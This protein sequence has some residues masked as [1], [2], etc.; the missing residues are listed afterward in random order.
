MSECNDT[1]EYKNSLNLTGT[2]GFLYSPTIQF[3]QLDKIQSDFIKTI[4]VLPDTNINSFIDNYGQ[5]KFNES[6]LS[7][8]NFLYSANLNVNLNLKVNYPLVQE[9]LDKGVAIT[10]IEFSSFM[11]EAGYNPI[12]IQTQQVSNPKK[13]L[14]LFNTY[15]NGAFSKS[16]MGSFCELAPSIFGAVA[17]FFTSVRNLA[18]TITDIINSIQNFSLA[19]LLDSLKKKILDVV[20]SAINKVKSIIENLSLQGVMD[21]AQ[22]IFQ[23]RVLY[24]FKQIKDQA[25]AFFEKDNVE[26]FTK[27]IEG[28]ISYATGLFK[29]IDIEEIQ[30]LIYRFCSFI[31]Q[32]ENIING[33]RNPIDAFSNRYISTYNLLKVRSDLNT[34]SAVAAG[35]K[36]FNND[37]VYAGA[38]SGIG[39]ETA[40]GNA[41]PPSQAE[42]D[43]VT[44]WNDGNGDGRITFVGGARDRGIESWTRVTPN[45]RVLAMRLQAKFGRQLK[46]TSAYRSTETQRQIIQK[47]VN[48]GKYPSFEAAIAS[49]KYARPGNSLHEKGTALDV[50][51]DGFNS[52]SKAEFIRIAREVGFSGIGGGYDTFV[53]IDTGPKREW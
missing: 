25:L 53:H 37:E 27:R 13:V 51:W 50:Q 31:N 38:I 49:K 9:G 1:L 8:N 18:N 15:V 42:V 45:T 21:Q 2:D 32:V 30:F 36:R 40:V 11:S 44:S 14:S 5:D 39:A 7:F 41:E 52:S 20:N 28:L 33:V 10:P 26:S 43:G 24:Q 12:S 3:Y 46:I 17:N 23:T 6:I 48:D 34:A 4:V 35:A 16:S 47:A 22:E 29:N 19:S